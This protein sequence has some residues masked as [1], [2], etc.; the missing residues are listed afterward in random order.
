M[1]PELSATFFI[2]QIKTGGHSP[3]FVEASDGNNYYVKYLNSLKTEEFALLVYEWCAVRLLQ[4]LKL[5]CADQALISI[6]PEIIPKT[7]DYS[8]SWKRN[9]LAWGSKE[10][11]N[12][13]LISEIKNF[14]TKNFFNQI[15]NPKDLIKIAI[16]DLWV[17]NC[18]RKQDNYN[19]I[20]DQN[21][22]KLRFIPIDHGAIF[23]GFDRIGIF[24]D[25][26]PCTS[27]NKLIVSALFKSIVCRIPQNEQLQISKDF[28]NLLSQVKVREV[29]NDVFSNIPESWKINKTLKDRIEKFLLSDLR[30]KSLHDTVNSTLPLKPKK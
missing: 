21:F 24:S 11:Q 18:D 12:N 9:A 17:E 10:I 25:A 16:F 28:I 6:P 1:I 5:P 7:I 3:L 30:I 29:L 13:I 20:M 19:L 2:N 4:E 27:S 15:E 26:L 23:G 14:S 8:K 22:N